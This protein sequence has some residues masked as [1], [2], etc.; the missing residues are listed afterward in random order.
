V[1]DDVPVYPI[2]AVLEALQ[3]EFPDVSVSKIR[4]LEAQGLVSP[5]RTASGYRQFSDADVELLRWILRQQR[6]HYLPLKVIKAR[7]RSGDRPGAAETAVPEHDGEPEPAA[8]PA[9]PVGGAEVE[10]AGPLPARSPEEE[11]WTAPAGR[12]LSR[13]ELAEQAGL[14]EAALAEL[15]S[16]G[17]LA[18]GEDGFEGEAVRVAQAAASFA[19]YG[20]EAR[21]LRMYKT[22][23]EREATFFDQV[24]PVHSRNEESRQE[25]REALAELARLGQTLRLAMLRSA[26]G[27]GD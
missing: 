20:V 14:P 27:R 11:L 12:P 8:P 6:D 1:A 7:L 13:S 19:R 24:L 10:A 5:G 18:P 23:A 25:R 21:H 17:L 22:F 9:P 4:F 15:E 2:G 16:F 26:L 3:E